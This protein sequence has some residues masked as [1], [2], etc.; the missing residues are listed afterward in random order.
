MREPVTAPER[1]FWLDGFAHTPR[2]SG[3][4]IQGL[5]RQRLPSPRPH[6]TGIEVR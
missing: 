2:T 3:A 6:P 1:Q 5:L 4:D